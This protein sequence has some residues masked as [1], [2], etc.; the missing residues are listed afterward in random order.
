[1]GLVV[2]GGLFVILVV[3][4]LFGVIVFSYLFLFVMFSMICDMEVVKF[5]E[6]WWLLVVEIK[7]GLGWVFW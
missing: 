4:F 2:V 5:F 1:M 6:D 7:E 3:F